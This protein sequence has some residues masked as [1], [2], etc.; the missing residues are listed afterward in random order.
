MDDDGSFLFRGRAD[1]VINS[2]GY[3]IS[4]GEVEAVLVKHPRVAQA[5]VVGTPDPVRGE[6]VKAFI[7]LGEGTAPSAGL[8][9][10]LQSL[11]KTELAAYEYP[12]QVEFIDALPMTVTGK[13]QRS[14]LRMRELDRSGARQQKEDLV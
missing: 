7:V 10:E 12:R 5:A 2:G 9:Q 8:E 6:A 13:I 14:V 3:R 11:V 1:D 4:P